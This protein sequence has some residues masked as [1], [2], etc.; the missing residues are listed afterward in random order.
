MKLCLS[1][2]VLACLA[3]LAVSLASLLAPPDP[4]L[5]VLIH[6]VSLND[7]VTG[8]SPESTWMPTGA[9]EDQWVPEWQQQAEAV[10]VEF[11]QREFAYFT[12]WVVVRLGAM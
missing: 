4:F 1:L 7:S 3:C 5:P 2:C 9:F 11:A 8:Y 12:R 10:I 6:A